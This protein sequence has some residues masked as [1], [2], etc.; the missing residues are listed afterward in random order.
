MQILHVA[1]NADETVGSTKTYSRVHMWAYMAIKYHKVEWGSDLRLEMTAWWVL[2]AAD[3]F[4]SIMQSA[5]A[6][7]A[8]EV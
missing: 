5:V 8:G 3:G 7:G 4:S 2:V 1:R 6:C